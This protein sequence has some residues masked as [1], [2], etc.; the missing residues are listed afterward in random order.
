MEGR[1]TLEI[2]AR[3]IG[4][5]V[6]V[7]IA[8]SGPGMPD[9]VAKRIFEPFF[10]TKAQ[11]VGTGLGLHIAHNIVVNRHKGRIRVE[12]RPG[13][14]A[15]H[16]VLP[17]S[18]G[19]AKPTAMTTCTHTDMIHDVTPESEAACRECEALGDSWVHLR[20]CLTCGHVG[21]CDSSKNQH[22][23]RHF[24]ASGH[25]VMQSFEIG[26]AWRYCFVDE[27]QLPDGQPFRPG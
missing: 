20:V 1:G 4:D 8:D 6:E 24:D 26:E 13:R 18:L 15:F 23:H 3:C 10:T 17:M 11:G 27:V 14:T 5:E 2:G 16:I 19:G 22:A 21:C 25:P 7:T 12:T 9:E